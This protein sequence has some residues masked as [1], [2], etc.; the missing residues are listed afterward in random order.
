MSSWDSVVI[1]VNLSGYSKVWKKS[2]T[3]F[4]PSIWPSCFNIASGISPTSK[5]SL[6]GQWTIMGWTVMLSAKW[7]NLLITKLQTSSHLTSGCVRRICCKL[8]IRSN[9]NN[10]NN[11]ITNLATFVTAHLISHVATINLT[12]FCWFHVFTSFRLQSQLLRGPFFLLRWLDFFT[13]SL[14]P[15]WDRNFCKGGAV[16]ILNNMGNFNPTF[17]SD[18]TYN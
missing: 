14:K 4:S 12:Y 5:M 1:Y 6:G 10:N 7:N 13:S 2:V 9:N 17:L 3:S 15:H 16:C 8:Q 11:K 18:P